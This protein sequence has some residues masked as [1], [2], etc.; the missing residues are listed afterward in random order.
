MS[1]CCRVTP[2]AACRGAG[3]SIGNALVV[4]PA[5][6]QLQAGGRPGSRAGEASRFL[7]A[8]RRR[9]GREGR[10]VYSSGELLSLANELCLAVRDVGQ[11][12]DQ[13]NQEGERV[14]AHVQ[15]CTPVATCS[16][17]CLVAGR[18]AAGMHT[19]SASV[20]PLVN[21]ACLLGNRLLHQPG[22]AGALDGILS[23]YPSGTPLSP[24]HPSPRVC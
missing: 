6:A 15:L 1:T 3:T 13:L 9:A 22:A 12:L 14:R 4:P 24:T 16:G 10:C 20:A 8:L 2:R 11:V 18:R 21:T 7:A 19:L 23:V 5:A 17:L